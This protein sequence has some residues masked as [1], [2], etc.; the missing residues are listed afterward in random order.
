MD[1]IGVGLIGSG[2]IAHYHARG[3]AEAADVE[4]P[5]L[6]SLDGKAAEEFADKY[7]IN[8][9]TDQINDMLG[10]ED[11]QAVVIS[12][13]NKFHA[14][15]AIEFMK[16]GIDVFVEKPMAV[17]ALQGTEMIECARKNER[18][19]MIG[20]MWRF[21][22]EVNY[23][24]DIV[25]SGKPG[26]IFKTKGYG[27]H[28]NWGPA[29]WFTE[30]E[31]AGGGALADMGVHAID[32]ARY[33]LG[34]PEP[35]EVYAKI[36]TSFGDYEVDD[37]G[38]VVITWETGAVSIIESGWW[39]PHADGPE[40]G[41]QVFGT[42]GYA[43]LFPTFWKKKQGDNPE[44][45]VP[46]MPERKEHCDQVMYSQQMKHFIECVRNRIKPVSGM[47][48]GQTVLR[49]VDAAYESARSGKVVKL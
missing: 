32:T 41:T 15:Y 43:S 3:L 12:T 14:P 30:K 25:Q 4:V 49:I 38:I 26:D 6:C 36:S 28:V 31:L 18:I 44:K 39:H 46:D 19:L 40:A 42:E 21:D 45:I 24:R 20:H 5:V 10:R 47:T 11:I 13:P 37:N 22:T 29:G 33:I 17:S 9:V 48:E 1:T 2:Y 35:K 23:I 34:D 8:D 27:I 16:N 7:G